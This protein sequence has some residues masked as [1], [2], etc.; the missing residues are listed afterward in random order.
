MRQRLSNLGHWVRDHYTRGRRHPVIDVLRFDPASIYR[1]HHGGHRP[2][3]RDAY[4]S[5]VRY[6]GG[7]SGGGDLLKTTVL[8]GNESRCF[9]RHRWYNDSKARVKEVDT[10]I[11]RSAIERRSRDP[12]RAFSTAESD[13]AIRQ[14]RD[15]KTFTLRW[16]TRRT[17][18]KPLGDEPLELGGIE[19]QFGS[20]AGITRCHE[21]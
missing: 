12:T 15:S 2:T 21:P 20:F 18:D 8:T 9:D 1:Q 7:D 17:R 5:A 14:L 16:L 6:T 4:Q 11:I 3:I 13:R 10:G 19:I